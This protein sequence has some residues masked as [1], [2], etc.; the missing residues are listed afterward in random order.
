VKL[1][2]VEMTVVPVT[3]SPSARVLYDE[4]DELARARLETDIASSGFSMAV[5]A[6]TRWIL[7][8][9]MI[10]LGSNERFEHAHPHASA[11]ASPRL[12]AY[13]LS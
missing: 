1:P 4:L 13:E 3:L 6:F 7:F 10:I 12:G 8:S 11:R 9:L 5:G 2:A